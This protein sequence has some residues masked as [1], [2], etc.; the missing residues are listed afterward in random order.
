MSIQIDD[1]RGGCLVVSEQT[2]YSDYTS[3]NLGVAYS[4]VCKM[5]VEINNKGPWFGVSLNNIQLK[6]FNFD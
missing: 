2:F 3:S 5:F 6:V 1:P 4:F